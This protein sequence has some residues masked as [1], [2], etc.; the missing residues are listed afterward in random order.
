[1]FIHVLCCTN[2][3]QSF[4]SRARLVLL[5]YGNTPV[6]CYPTQNDGPTV[7]YVTEWRPTR[8]LLRLYNCYII[9]SERVV[10]KRDL[11][12]YQCIAS[13]AL[14]NGLVPRNF[15]A[16]L[17][18][19]NEF[20]IAHLSHWLLIL[21]D[22]SIRP[23]FCV[24]FD[25]HNSILTCHLIKITKNEDPKL[26]KIWS[27]LV[28]KSGNIRRPSNFSLQKHQAELKQWKIRLGLHL[29]MNEHDTVP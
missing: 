23:S 29:D 18:D 15:P 13:V 20:E 14:A 10:A 25:V 6:T 26:V 27:K 5:T 19:Q 22:F 1:M 3:F 17:N 16:P 12:Q 28:Q 4:F 11:S 24:T 8:F 2:V 9:L 21:C 7:R